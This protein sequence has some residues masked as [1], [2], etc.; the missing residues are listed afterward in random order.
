MKTNFYFILLLNAAL[1]IQLAVGQSL[2]N[3]L[4]TYY[5]SNDNATCNLP[6]YFN[7]ST[8][9]RV[10]LGDI[11]SLGSLKFSPSLCG[12]ILSVQCALGP[13]VNVMV[14]NTNVGG[15]L[16]LYIP[17]WIRATLNASPGNQSCSVQMTSNNTFLTPGPICFYLP[18]MPADNWQFAVGLLNVGNK[19]VTNA[20][21]NGIRGLLQSSAPYFEFK[22]TIDVAKPVIFGF[23][24]GSVQQVLF[25]SCISQVQLIR[26]V[27]TGK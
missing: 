1:F 21:Q 25:G 17:S 23:S 26:Q 12:H 2:T 11:S 8:P 5:D 9:Y 3:I 18:R 15:G 6:T 14:V 10:A 13:A 20:T 4:T 7:F 24:D 22:Q 27:N 19:L 16:G